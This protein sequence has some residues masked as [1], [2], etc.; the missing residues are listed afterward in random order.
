[1]TTCEMHRAQLSLRLRHL[2]DA[3][4]MLGEVESAEELF[5][6]LL[7]IARKVTDAASASLMIYQPEKETLRFAWVEDEVVGNKAL[8]LLEQAGELALGQGLAGWAA[9]NLEPVLIEDAQ[10]DPRFNSNMDK[11]TGFITRTLI[12]VPLHNGPELLGVITVLNAKNRD[13]FDSDDLDILTSFANL[14][15]MALVR[16]QLLEKRLQDE[17]LQVEMQSAAKIQSLFWP[18]PIKTC[19]GS[20]CWATCRPAGFVGGDIYDLIQTADDKWLF[21][22]ADVSGKG[23][24]AA[25]LTAALSFRVRAEVLHCQEPGE[26]MARIN[27]AMHQLL[28]GEGHF[29]TMILG[30]YNPQNNLITLARAGHPDPIWVHD[31]KICQVPPTDGLTLGVID[32]AE[33]TTCELAL[34]PG[35]SLILYSDGLNEAENLRAEIIGLEKVCGR[36]LK[37]SKPPR[38]CC[39]PDLVQDWYNGLDPNDDLTLLELWREP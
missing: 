11:T 17:R 18:Q 37:E 5:P 31:N 39:L 32:E 19:Q 20:H 15:S 25:L 26:L 33:F 36:L 2:I 35:D 22:L 13:H 28:S 34:A 1:M 16:N 27:A 38:A 10:N 14:A 12:T 9:A 29:V 8:K 30:S 3:S 23:M 7:N 4:I 21:Y 6:R 24:S